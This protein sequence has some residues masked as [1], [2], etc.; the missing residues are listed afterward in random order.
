[1]P[2]GDFVVVVETMNTKF[3]YRPPVCLIKFWVK[4]NLNLKKI[5]SFS[6]V[7]SFVGSLSTYNRKRMKQSSPCG[8]AATPPSDFR[9]FT[10]REGTKIQ[11]FEIM[12]FVAFFSSS[13]DNT[14]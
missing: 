11:G 1:M 13:N 10:E 8:H 2:K 9:D 12:L 6:P 7:K 14:E 4:P 3:E 5:F